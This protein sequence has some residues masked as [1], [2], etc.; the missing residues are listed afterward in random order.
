VSAGRK[1]R[2]EEQRPSPEHKNIKRWGKR[3]SQPRGMRR[4]WQIRKKPKRV[5]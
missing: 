4:E 1:S 2:K 5:W 3:K